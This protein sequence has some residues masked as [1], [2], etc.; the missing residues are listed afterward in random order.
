M[1]FKSLILIKKKVKVG[2]I[3]KKHIPDRD[4]SAPWSENK[5]YDIWGNDQQFENA[6]HTHTR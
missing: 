5:A 3:K 2:T 6:W 4:W 1:L